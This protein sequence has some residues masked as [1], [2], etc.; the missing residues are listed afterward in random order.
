[1]D[2][3]ADIIFADTTRRYDGRALETEPLGG[4]ESSVIRLARELAR[5]KHSVTV[6]SNCDGPV[7]HAGVQWRPLGGRMASAC[8]LYVAVQHPG[9]LGLVKQAR[10]RAIWVL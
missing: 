2:P 7:E 5:R 8:D 10:R 9:L 4:T 3:M 1:M 6:Y